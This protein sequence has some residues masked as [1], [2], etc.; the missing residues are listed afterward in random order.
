MS[1]YR[2]LAHPLDLVDEHTLEGVLVPWEEV[3]TVID[4]DVDGRIDRYRE[5]FERGAFDMQLS[6]A[7]SGV[8]RKVELRDQHAGGLGKMGYALA[9]EDRDEGLFGRFR[10]RDANVR[11][12]QQMYADGIDGLSI[13]FHP[14][15]RGGTRVDGYGDEEVRTRTRAYLEHAA[16]VAT[17]AYPTARVSALRD[18]EGGTMV[19]SIILGNGVAYGTGTAVDSILPQP[20]TT[21]VPPPNVWV[22]HPN[23]SLPNVSVEE[24][25]ERIEHEDSL[26]RRQREFDE[27]DAWLEQTRA[28]RLQYGG[29][30]TNIAD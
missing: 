2:D 12:V 9:L 27:L 18:D 24:V 15:P 20:S 14:L 7:Q 1:L 23:I 22:A 13:S 30:G 28:K 10:V 3:A 29:D 5:R 17:P 21:Y 11:D 26:V 6:A 4:V 25:V 8:I 16:L 19:G